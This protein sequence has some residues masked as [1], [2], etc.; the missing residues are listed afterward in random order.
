MAEKAIGILIAR[1]EE[2]W[3]NGRLAR[4]LKKHL[5]LDRIRQDAKPSTPY[6][7]DMMAA[8]S[9]ALLDRQQ[10]RLACLAS[11]QDYAEPSAIF[12][13]PEPG[14]WS[15]DE[16]GFNHAAH[17][18]RPSVKVFTSWDGGRNPYDRER[19]VSFEAKTFSERD[20]S[21]RYEANVLKSCSWVNGVWDVRGEE[22]GTYYFP[23][24]G[25]TEVPDDEAAKREPKRVRS[26]HENSCGEEE[27]QGHSLRRR[28]Q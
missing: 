7:L 2:T 22:M 8:I 10:L 23:L 3:I 1:L 24:P 28:F 17:D 27:S 6:V 25:I 15:T 5:E 14:A 4:Y 13:A 18:M 21:H 11:A 19:F 9:R 12:I 16:D 26:F 20:G